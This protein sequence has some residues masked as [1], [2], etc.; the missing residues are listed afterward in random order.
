MNSSGVITLYFF[1]IS[2]LCHVKVMFIQLLN[3]LKRYFV[4]L[5]YIFW[6]YL[7]IKYVKGALIITNS[8]LG[9]WCVH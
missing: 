8:L 2:M 6:V 7:V 3:L 4:Y 1:T 5:H 9:I